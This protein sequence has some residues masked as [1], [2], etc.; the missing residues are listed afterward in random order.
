MTTEYPVGDPVIMALLDAFSKAKWLRINTD[1][2][3]DPA[4]DLLDP[5]NYQPTTEAE[6]IAWEQLTNPDVHDRLIAFI[7]QRSQLPISNYVKVIDHL[8]ATES[9][10][11]FRTSRGLDGVGY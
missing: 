9:E 1:D 8:L 4:K 5:L 2:S 6:K 11:R 7:E 10:R 3:Y